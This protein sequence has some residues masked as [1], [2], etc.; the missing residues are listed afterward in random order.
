MVESQLSSP[1]T[2]GDQGVPQGSL[3]WPFCFLL[4]YNDFPANRKQGES[5]LYAD[6]ST[7]NVS[8]AHPKDLQNKVQSEAETSVSWVKDNLICSGNKT[9]L[10]VIGTKELRKSRLED[11]N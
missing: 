8:S 7:D 4:F 10:M 9:K 1:L 11:P 5:V 3:L 6:D 2:V